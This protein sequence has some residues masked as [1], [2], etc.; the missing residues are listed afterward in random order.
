M[1]MTSTVVY[2]L[3]ADANG[4]LSALV[5]VPQQQAAACVPRPDNRLVILIASSSTARL[6]YWENSLR[7]MASVIAAHHVDALVEVLPRAGATVLLLD[8]DLAGLDGARS[9]AAL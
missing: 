4:T 7:A 1:N 6:A 2:E 8:F 9:V 5:V 3:P